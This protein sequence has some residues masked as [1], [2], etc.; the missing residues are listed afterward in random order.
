[1][2]QSMRLLVMGPILGWESANRAA[3]DLAAKTLEHYGYTALIP[4]WFMSSDPTEHEVIKTCLETLIRCQG[5]A[6]LSWANDDPI[7]RLIRDVTNQLDMPIT[8]VG[9]WTKRD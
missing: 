2:S 9:T 8:T 5:V 7:F 4:H 3:F 6:V 1:M